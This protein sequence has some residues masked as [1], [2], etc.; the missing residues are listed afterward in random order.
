MKKLVKELLN[1]SLESENPYVIQFHEEYPDQE[2]SPSSYDVATFI[3]DNWAE[4][5]GLTNR[6]KDEESYFPSEVEEICDELGIDM[7]NFSEAWSD[8]REGANDWE[9]DDED[10]DEDEEEEIIGYDRGT[11]EPIYGPKDKKHKK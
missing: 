1:E 2:N 10:D 7:D 9:D 6:D 5:T 4:I 8:I 11:M 3:D